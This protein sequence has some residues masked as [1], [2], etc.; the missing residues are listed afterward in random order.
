MAGI[1]GDD[2]RIVDF[3]KYCKVCKHKEKDESEE[4][5]N[6]CL[7]EPLNYNTDKP[8]KYEEK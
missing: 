6:E 3:S 7:S 1:V 8:T 4:P 2:R 5:R